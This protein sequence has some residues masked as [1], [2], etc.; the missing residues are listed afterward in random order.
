MMLSV[1]RGAMFQAEVQTKLTFVWI[2]N[3][4]GEN[5][6]NLNSHLGFILD[7]KWVLLFCMLRKG[8]ISQSWQEKEYQPE[9]SERA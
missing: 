6:V 1:W 4:K 2:A 9:V 8:L 7:T 3:Y 5:T